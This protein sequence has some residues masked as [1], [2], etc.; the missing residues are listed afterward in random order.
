MTSSAYLKDLYDNCPEFEEL[1]PVYGTPKTNW[2]HMTTFIL[3]N[4]SEDLKQ[5]WSMASNYLKKKD[6]HDN[7]VRLM[8]LSKVKKREISDREA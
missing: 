3:K 8:A 2:Q 7:I 5:R 4:S 6:G 1:V